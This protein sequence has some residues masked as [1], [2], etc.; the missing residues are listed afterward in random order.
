MKILFNCLVALIFTACNNE[1]ASNKNIPVI[2]IASAMER[3]ETLKVT[4]IAD[5]ISYIP[6]ETNDTSLI[7]NHPDITV[8]NDKILIT[9]K[10][11]PIK[12]FDKNT[13][14][15]IRN[16]GHIGDDPSGYSDTDGWGNILFWVDQQTGVVYIQGWQ[17]DLVRYNQ[18]GTFLGKTQLPYSTNYLSC[19]Y[20]LITNNIVISNNKAI[21]NSNPFSI[22]SFEGESGMFIDSVTTSATPLPSDFVYG[23]YFYGD[24]IGNGGHV[25]TSFTDDEAISIVPIS[26]SLWVSNN[27]VRF[28]ENFVDTVF[29]VDGNKLSPYLIIN[30]GKYSWPYKERFMKERGKDR[31]SIDYM[32]E[33]NKSIYFHFKTDMYKKEKKS[34]CGIF[35]KSKNST[36]I[37]DNDKGLKDDITD[38]MPVQIRKVTSSG[39]YIGLIQAS[40]VVEWMDTHADKNINPQLEI[41]KKMKEEDNPIVVIME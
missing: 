14:K 33:S 4:D 25:M 15:F 5:K 8:Y 38:F 22:M 13:G 23:S 9:S 17:N 29:T 12:M 37:M 2:D 35:D 41:L 7:G 1:S 39:E 40:E 21:S 16:I 27:K 31:I 18:Q 24:Y 3:L 36:R 6:L 10:N 30:L 34:Y 20:L 26:P 32:F 11:Q 28:K 19:C